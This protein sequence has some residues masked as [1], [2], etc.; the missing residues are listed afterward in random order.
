MTADQAQILSIL[1]VT[2]GMF[3]WGRWRH[4]IIALGCL[5]A[6]VFAGLVPSGSAFSG[7][8]H[9]AVITVGCVLILS[10]GLQST[11][12]VD[13]L[14]QRAL[15][16]TA[17]PTITI[18]SITALGA[19]LSAFMNNVGALA[20]LMP[21]AIQIA[22]R[23]KIPPGKVLM[24]LAFGTILGGMTTMIGTPPNLIVS[25]FR[26][27]T[28]MGSFGMFD[29]TPVGL[30]VAA[31]GVLFAALAGWR[32]VP[33]R[34]QK[35]AE[36]FDTG[37]YL[38]ETRIKEGARAAGKT[39][40]EVEKI[41][42]EA[43]AQ[44]IGMIRND[45]RVSAPNIRRILHPEDILIIE[46]DP[47]AL[48]GALSSLGLV[49][50]DPVEADKD[51][52]EKKEQQETI[53]QELAVMPNSR[54]IGR[55]ADDVSLRSRYGLNLLAISRTGRR[56]VKRLKSTP[57]KAGDVLLLQGEPG[58]LSGFASSFGSVPLAARSIAIPDKRK[59]ILS[60]GVMIFAIGGAA[61]GLLPAAISFATGVLALMLLRI[62]PLRKLY[63][64]V[65][66]PVIVLLGALIPVAMA[67]ETTGAADLLA[68]SLLGTVARG[69]PVIALII[70][71]VVTMT[72]SDLMNN[73][74]TAAVMAPI[75]ISTAAQLNSSA[76]TF[77]MAVAIGAS[78]AFLT[79][80]GHQNNTLIL[81]PGGFRFGDYW[82]LGL[83]ME[84]LVVAIGVP[85][86][87]IIWP[88]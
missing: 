47:E 7:F 39:V 60:V 34:E 83:P 21:V 29:F 44:I 56:S 26:E 42:E 63:D 17:G 58:S 35:G 6:C 13:L 46:A 79:P 55:S 64:A 25:G 65:D 8:G 72:R 59:T 61:F 57:I 78:C 70:I 62:V 38:L 88:L 23:L 20:L 48:G 36:G 1:A 24:P 9:P 67:M 32:I 86:L 87:L 33:G 75:S 2:I 28:G 22:G 84:I 27:Q 66:W 50:E 18:A 82:K 31:C 85:M 68:R 30:A 52:E 4:D 73:A 5:L 12:A 14:A 53:L 15:P 40:G 54:L 3:L 41:L 74:A 69:S 51:S 10:W 16:A 80:I 43:D 37:V 49:L 45:F 19:V 71:L 76:D 81:G 77:L 11:G